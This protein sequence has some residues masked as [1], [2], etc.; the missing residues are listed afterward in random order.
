[1]SGSLSRRAVLV[2]APLLLAI[3]ALAGTSPIA[4]IE[5][6]HGGRLGLFAIDTGS[7]RTLEH[8]A[9]ERFLMCS[10]FKALLAAQVLKRIEAGGEGFERMVS[11]TRD[12]LIFTSPTTEA[13]VAK[14]ALSVETLLKAM[15]ELSD[16]T[17]AILLMRRSGGPAGLTAWVR[18]L[19]DSVTRSDR[20]EPISND[21][22]GDLDTTS[23]RAIIATAR[24]ILL[25]DA[26]AEQSRDRLERWMIAC[27][28]GLNRIRAALP[29]DWQAGDRPG[30]SSNRET[31]DFALIRPPGRA[32]LLVAAYYDAPNL[33]FDQREAVLREVG[34][35]FV[36]WAG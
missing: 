16:N 34:H 25:G 2:G 15:V 24:T 14:G 5:K 18:G 27:K 1:M 6:K 9:D 23:P 33:D 12:D 13:N 11:Y 17:A 36:K 31:N 8:R 29:P 35:A 7:G 19:G 10:T 28:P 32:P 22:N 3:P 30:T 26:L 4:E 21:Y 20:Y